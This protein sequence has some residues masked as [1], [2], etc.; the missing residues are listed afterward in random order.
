MIVRVINDGVEYALPAEIFVKPED[1]VGEPWLNATA[2][3]NDF[4][5]AGGAVKVGRYVLA[6]VEAI[7]A[8][9]TLQRTVTVGGGAARG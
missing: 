9:V 6:S 2:N 3:V 8:L 4:A 1:C 5:V 7:T